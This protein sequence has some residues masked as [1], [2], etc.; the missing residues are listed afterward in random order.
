M[1]LGEFR[2]WPEITEQGLETGTVYPHPPPPAPPKAH[3]GNDAS[4]AAARSHYSELPAPGWLGAASA[5][6]A[7]GHRGPPKAAAPARSRALAFPGGQQT[8]PPAQP[9]LP[10]VFLTSYWNTAV[11]AV[12][13]LWPRRLLAPGKTTSRPASN[14]APPRRCW[15]DVRVGV[16]ACASACA[17]GSGPRVSG[18]LGGGGVGVEGPPSPL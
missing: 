8:G 5:F 6:L 18:V 7:P 17:K 12:F 2:A 9:A 11:P 3:L 1:E 10:P 13:A 4:L 14:R 16:R 15:V